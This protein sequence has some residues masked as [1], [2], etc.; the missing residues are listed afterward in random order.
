MAILKIA[1][2][3]SPVL[4]FPADPVETIQDQEIQ[5][6]IDDMIETM[7]ECQIVALAAP[8]VHR[9]F[10]IVIIGAENTERSRHPDPRSP[11]VLV[12]PRVAPIEDRTEEAWESCPSIPGLCGTVSRF[13]AIEVAARDREGQPFTL[14][15][16]NFLAR[17]IQHET[18]HLNG[19]LF[20][21]RMEGCETLTFQEE[22]ERYWLSSGGQTPRG[23]ASHR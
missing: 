18:D 12:N 2:L 15:A 20:L 11:I 4:R 21:D 22:F 16:S 3:G 19:K 10:Q 13:A 23:S 7:R 6:L 17:V 5:R 14:K 8:Q 1:R 9:S